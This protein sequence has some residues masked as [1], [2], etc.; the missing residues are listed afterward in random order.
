MTAEDKDLTPFALRSHTLVPLS[1]AYFRDDIR[2]R[3]EAF[4]T[5]LPL[6]PQIED[7]ER[8]PSPSVGSNV[9]ERTKLGTVHV[10]M[11]FPNTYSRNSSPGP[12]YSCPVRGRPP[13]ANAM[14]DGPSIIDD[15]LIAVYEDYGALS[16]YEMGYGIAEES[17][18]ESTYK[19]LE[20][21]LDLED[22]S[23]G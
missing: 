17:A 15:T 2:R 3:K 1:L 8:P 16:L 11:A 9:S 20:I 23:F 14:D 18:R 13:F 12:T 22:A 6:E 7:E 5:S 10:S 21:F 4:E 19:P